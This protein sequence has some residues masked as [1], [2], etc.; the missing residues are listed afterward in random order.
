MDAEGEHKRDLSGGGHEKLMQRRIGECEDLTSERS[1]E[2]LGLKNYLN[3]TG[4][5]GCKTFVPA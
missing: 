1:E 2:F 5:Q 4:C 3:Y